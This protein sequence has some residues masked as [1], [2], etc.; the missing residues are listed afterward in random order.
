MKDPNA[1]AVTQDNAPAHHARKS[2][3]QNA[4]AAPAHAAG[5]AASNA[6]VTPAHAAGIA[7]SNAAVTPAH[8]AGIAAQNAAVT[9]AHAVGIAAQNAAV[10][11]AHAVKKRNR[12][13]TAVSARHA[14][15]W[16]LSLLL[17]PVWRTSSTQRAKNSKKPYKLHVP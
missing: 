10:T 13:R 1:N 4:V 8:A 12:V 11:P 14:T 5:I 17:K 2:A 3:A 6:A 9:P 15:L 16:N 7:A